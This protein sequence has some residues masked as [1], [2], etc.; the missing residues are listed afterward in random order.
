MATCTNRLTISRQEV[1]ARVL[2]ALRDK[3]MRRD[4][5]EDFCR[6]Y[7]RELN[8]LREALERTQNGRGG[9]LAIAGEPG[10][11][12]TTVVETFLRGIEESC[13][14]GRGRCSERLAGT[15]PHLPV[16]EALDEITTVEPTR[17]DVLRRAAPT[18]FQ[19]SARPSHDHPTDC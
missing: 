5:F 10:I 18:W 2:V 16:L 14:I 8:R 7:V 4:L 19:H 9:I 15:E 12:K 1:E 3:L 17:L 11:G 13:V 6:E